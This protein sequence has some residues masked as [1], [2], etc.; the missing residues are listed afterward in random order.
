MSSK[1]ARRGGV[2]DVVGRAD[3]MRATNTI[4]S[5][6]SAEF[7]PFWTERASVGSFPSG[8]VRLHAVKSSQRKNLDN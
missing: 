3:P 6:P 4:E 1:R 8:F 2:R 5:A 7:H